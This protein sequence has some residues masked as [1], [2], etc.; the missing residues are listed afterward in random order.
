MVIRPHQRVSDLS[1]GERILVLIA[2]L[3]VASI[4]VKLCSPG[5][6][7]FKQRRSRRRPQDVVPSSAP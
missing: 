3:L 1:A 7:L 4:G 6:I 2:P 5:P